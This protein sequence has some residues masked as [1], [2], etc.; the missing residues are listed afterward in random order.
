MVRAADCVP[1]LLADRDGGVVG[2]AHCGRPGL[3]AGIV[4][5]TVAAHAR[6]RRRA[7]RRRGSD[8][9]CAAAATRCPRRCR[10][11][12]SPR[13]SRRADADHVV[14]HSVARPRRRGPR[15]ARARRRRWSSTCRGAPASR[16][17]SSPTVAT[18]RGRA[19]RPGDRQDRAHEHAA[20]RSPPA[21]TPYAAASP[22]PAA[23]AGR[24]PARGHAGRRSPSSSPRATSGILADLG[25]TDVG[26]NR[27]PEAG[28]KRAECA[29]LPTHAGTSSAGCRATRR[30]PSASYADVVE[31]VDR[32]KLVTA[33]DRGGPPARPRGRRAPPGEPRP[34]RREPGARAPTRRTSPAW[35]RAVRGGRQA[36]AARPDGRRAARRGPARRRSP[37]W[38]RSA[39]SSCAN[40]RTPPGSRRG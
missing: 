36:P 39:R 22:T 16:P 10:T 6:P 12:R 5:A 17:T 23:A 33:L 13:S 35:P 21:S 37:G 30:R 40:T 4:P 15:P 20:T 28:D 3:V 2:A 38:P 27:H 7:A 11:P 25:V 29:D 32:T 26:E 9:T 31:S 18:V 14:G 19:G 34:A 1:V 8:R 24:D